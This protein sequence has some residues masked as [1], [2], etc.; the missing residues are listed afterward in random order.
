MQIDQNVLIEVFAQ[1]IATKEGFHKS[2]KIPS[3]AQRLN[4]PLCLEHWK[5]RNGRPYPVVNGYVKFPDAETGLA[6]GRSQCKINIVKRKL[7]FREFFAGKSKVY[8]GFCPRKDGKSD[9]V[10]YAI[11][12]LRFVR[13][14]LGLP[15]EIT[16][17]TPIHDLIAAEM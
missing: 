7:T 4:N 13:N 2:S 16:I 12:V 5:D 10:A 8:E 1:A 6:A 3:I 14:R 15:A 9:P 11:D 17:D